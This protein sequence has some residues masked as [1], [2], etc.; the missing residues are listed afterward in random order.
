[1]IE[2]AGVCYRAGELEVLRDLTFTIERGTTLVLL[3]RSGTGKT[4]ALK[5]INAL[6]MPTSGEV[7][8]DGKSTRDWDP[9]QLRRRVGYVIQETGL[10]PHFT[11][12]DNVAVVP[13]LHDWPP[14]RIAARVEDLLQRVGLAPK[15]F[16]GRYP[17]DLSGG[18]R[19][20]VGVAR[21]LAADPPVL[22]FDEP[23]GALDP[24]TRFE[25]RREF[26]A[27]ARD[28]GK[29]TLFVTHDVREALEL[30]DRIALLAGGNL[31]E[32]L[33][34]KEFRQ[35]KSAEARAFLESLQSG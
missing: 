10:F 12:F 29:T 28:L 20:R 32:L 27:L 9:V 26:R 25:L 5:M 33:P 4:T 14:E 30:G 31:R 35:A 2:F 18:Q 11:V 1:M 22:L 34:A 13:R 19:Q 23:F 16:A 24:V 7:R 3:G 17:R 21:A 6:V 8:V 15:D